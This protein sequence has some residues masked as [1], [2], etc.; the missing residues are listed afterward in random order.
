MDVPVVRVLTCECMLLQVAGVPSA[1][2]PVR[3]LICGL[4]PA[5][6]PARRR[7]GPQTPARPRS[8]SVPIEPFGVGEGYGVMTHN[9]T[10]GGAEHFSGFDADDDAGADTPGIVLRGCRAFQEHT[11]CFQTC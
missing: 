9:R 11:F 8:V 3:V 5:K 4:T 6:N 10:V 7:S 2:T 1:T